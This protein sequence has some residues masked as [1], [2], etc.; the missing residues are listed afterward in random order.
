MVYS[1]I[2]AETADISSVQELMWAR[3]SDGMPI[4]RKSR[5]SRNFPYASVRVSPPSNAD[6]T[7]S[8]VSGYN[9]HSMAMDT[10]I[11]T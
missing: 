4:S 5:P 9:L 3:K 1:Y 7:T 2:N 10:Y 11:W 6:C 8:S